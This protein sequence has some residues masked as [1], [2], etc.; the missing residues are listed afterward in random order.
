MFLLMLL[1]IL[2][3]GWAADITV[4]NSWNGGFQGYFKLNPSQA[5]HGWKVHLVFDKPVDNIEIWRAEVESHTPTEWV[6]HNMNFDADINPGADFQVDFVARAG[7]DSPA[8][9]TYFIEGD[10]DSGSGSGSGTGGGSATQ[11][12]SSGGGSPITGGPAATGGST[13]KYNYGDALGLSILFFDAQRSGRLP[14]NNPIPWRGDSAVN[15][16][17]SGHDLS[18]GWYDAGDHVKFNLPMS[19]SSWVLNYGF[20]KFTDAYTSAGQKDMMCDMVKWP[21]EY[22]KKCW[23]PD[24]QTLYVQVGDGYADHGFWGRPENMNM[25]RPAYKVNTG[26]HGAD[27]AGNT[28]AA[29]ASG[30]LIFKDICGDAAFADSLLAAAKSL[31]TF[32]KN[33]RG[34][35]TDCVTQARDFYGSSGDADELS[36]AAIWLHKATGDNAYLQDAKS[37]YPAGTAWGFNWNDANVGAA[38]L[39]YEVTKEGKYKNDIDAFIRQYMPGGSVP[40][41]PCGL[42]FR[43]KWGPN[44]HAANAAFIAAVAA[45]DGLSPD[46]YKK[47]ALSQINYILGDNKLH[48]SYE[49]GFGNH[50][51]KKP[52]HRGSSCPTNTNSCDPGS[53]ADNP[54]VLKGGLVGGPDQGD[55]YDDR[56]DDYVKN[57]VACDY[58]AG[59]Q[60]ALAGLY[61]FSVNNELPPAPAAK[62]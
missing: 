62:C 49:I 13:M 28:V 46:E 5:L 41:T 14:S 42:S 54:N 59:F 26:C 1:G 44:R 22:F 6:V 8:H 23:I 60:G 15:D 32:A 10:G 33:N 7:G 17:D 11:P 29:M 56:R 43:D 47:Y 58:N 24:Q 50:F 48:I 35:Y 27:V 36:A 53:G 25:G 40:M 61:H 4:T 16:G 51:P 19:F 21:L 18:G 3:S 12:P 31:Y 38:C 55:N 34:K 39:L 2:G 30:Y 20:L 45:A 9:G 37:F 57:E 52:H